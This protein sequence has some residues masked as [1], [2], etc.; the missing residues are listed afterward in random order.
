MIPQNL[1]EVE[2]PRWQKILAEGVETVEEL[3]NL[4]EIERSSIPISFKASHSFP[5]RVPRGFVKRM[6]KGDPN[7]P[8]L[9]QV[10]P[11]VAEEALDDNYSTDPLG[12][13]ASNPVPGLLH[14]Y[15][16]RVLLTLT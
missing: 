6:K 10:L 12:E 13:V 14:K 8:L 7:D 16:N 3:L 9:R 5:L 4:L 11:L 15:E 2:R 1:N